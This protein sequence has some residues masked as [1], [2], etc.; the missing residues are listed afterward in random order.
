[1]IDKLGLCPHCNKDW[2]G[3]DAYEA[4]R[5]MSVH[6]LTPEKELRALAAQFGWTPE[7]PVKLSKVITIILTDD[8]TLYEC[9]KCHHVFE[10][11]SE[12]KYTSLYEAKQTL[13]AEKEEG[14][15]T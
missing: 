15:L 10:K 2:K 12:Q 7:N 11:D 8:I 13:F 14:N 9:P 3:K 5:S 6:I 1:M 4:I